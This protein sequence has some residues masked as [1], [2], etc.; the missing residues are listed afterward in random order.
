MLRQKPR[1]SGHG[2]NRLNS[3]RFCADCIAPPLCGTAPGR[4]TPLYPETIEALIDAVMQPSLSQLRDVCLLLLAHHSRLSVTSLWRLKW[5]DVSLRKDR[6]LLPAD[7]DQQHRQVVEIPASGGPACPVRATVRWHA[8]QARAVGPVFGTRDREAMYATLASLGYPPKA[9]TKGPLPSATD[10]RATVV[11][12]L[13]PSARQTQDRAILLIGFAGAL[14]T[15]EMMRLRWSHVREGPSSL[16]LLVPGRPTSIRVEQATSPVY[17]P[18]Q[19]WAN[20]RAIREI[21][22]EEA[23]R[24]FAFVDARGPQPWTQPATYKSLNRVVRT[25]ARAAGVEARWGFLSVRQGAIRSAVRAGLPSHEIAHLAGL[26]TFVSVA[27][28]ES[29]ENL[30]R[31]SVA[32]RVGL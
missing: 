26:R 16:S 20:W 10:L 8:A 17:C 25:A 23:E 4:E 22:P 7:K 31:T 30:I 2:A 9:L 1:V 14:S 24:T 15:L 32:G 27:S 12:L 21:A 19:A 6:I 5:A 28:Y 11:Q 29:A 3:G 13:R 18:V